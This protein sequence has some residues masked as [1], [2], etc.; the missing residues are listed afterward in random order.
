M[1]SRRVSHGLIFIYPQYDQIINRIDAIPY[2]TF[3][4]YI[5]S[6]YSFRFSNKMCDLLLENKLYCK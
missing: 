6:F 3:S 4:L 1:S 5:I 2:F